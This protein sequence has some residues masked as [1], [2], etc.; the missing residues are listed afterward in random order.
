M[1]IGA[2]RPVRDVPLEL[3]DPARIAALNGGPPDDHANELDDDAH[4]FS[5]GTD[6][7][8]RQRGSK[9]LAILSYCAV[10]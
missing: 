5:I 1:A 7:E 3:A 2:E 6:V 8:G 10:V 9:A 4:L